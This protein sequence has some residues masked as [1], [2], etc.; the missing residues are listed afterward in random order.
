[1]ALEE[2][3]TSRLQ[4]NDAVRNACVILASGHRSVGSLLEVFESHRTGPGAPTDPQQDLLRAMVLFAASTLDA[5]VKQ[6]I[7]DALFV[8]IER[9]EGAQSQLKAFVDRRLRRVERAAPEPGRQGLLDVR[10]LAEVIA[11]GNPRLVLVNDLI[12]ELTGDSL[13]SRD[14]LL[15][16]AA[17]FAVTRE[18]I[19]DDFDV[20][21][22]IFRVRNEIAHEMDIELGQRTRTRRPRKREDMVRFADALL[23]TAFR[24]VKSVDLKTR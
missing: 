9:D 22:L 14:Q 15:R 16:V 5:V 7:R 19:I 8:V 1:M 3:D 2:I 11:S 23:Q 18:E 17:H 6:L 12:D 21:A 24:F 4:A 20:M 10:Y 13:Q